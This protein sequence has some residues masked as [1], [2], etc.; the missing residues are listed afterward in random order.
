MTPHRCHPVALPILASL[1]ILLLVHELPA[2]GLDH[3]KTHYTKYEY[4]IP[5]RDGVRLF[6]AVYVP[7][8][9]AHKYPMLMIRTQSG[10]RPYGTDQ[11]P[12]DLGPSPLFG[13][14]RYIFV[15][16]DVRGRWAS[17]GTFVNM[18][19]HNSGKKGPGDIDESSDTYDT[20][21]WLLKHVPN[22]NGN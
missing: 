22:H 19:P 1:S 15:Y 12:N 4:R 14:E 18:R 8:D 9:V 10:V 3:V 20:I 13:R 11:Y 5:M 16:Q 21:G 6:T 17:E 2:Q 7:K